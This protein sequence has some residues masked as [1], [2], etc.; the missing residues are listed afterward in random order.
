MRTLSALIVA[1][2]AGAYAEPEKFKLDQFVTQGG[3][4]LFFVDAMRVNLDSANRGGMLSF[5]SP[6]ASTTYC[7]STAC[8]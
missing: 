1:K 5:P 2:P 7:S 6:W 8:A 4:A 3:S